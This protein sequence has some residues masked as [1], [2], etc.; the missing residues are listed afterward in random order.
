[1]NWHNPKTKKKEDQPRSGVPILLLLNSGEVHE[2]HFIKNA[3]RY[4]MNTNRYRIY[5]TGKTVEFDE[6]QMWAN[7]PV[8]G[9]VLK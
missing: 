1:M 5:K 2:G 6:V 7:M 4:Q 3:N 8:V 9:Q